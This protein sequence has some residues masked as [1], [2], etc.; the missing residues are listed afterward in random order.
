MRVWTELL[1]IT[2]ISELN[3]WGDNITDKS[4]PLFLKMEHLSSLDL[5]V[6]KITDED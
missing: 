3:L 1:Q 2:A 5:S 4:L 6:T